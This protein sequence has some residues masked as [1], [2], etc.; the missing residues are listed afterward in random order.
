[1]AT[2]VIPT[3]VSNLHHA[4]CSMPSL[5]KV[6]SIHQT[7]TKNMQIL[8][9]IQKEY[10]TSRL[11][12]SF[13][14][15]KHDITEWND[16]TPNT[17]TMS[18]K[19]LNINLNDE[20]AALTENVIWNKKSSEIHKL[21]DIT[22]F[23]VQHPKLWKDVKNADNIKSMLYSTIHSQFDNAE[24]WKQPALGTRMRI[25]KCE[26]GTVTIMYKIAEIMH[27]RQTY[28]YDDTQLSRARKSIAYAMIS[29]GIHKQNIGFIIHTNP[30]EKDVV[31]TVTTSPCCTHGQN[32]HAL[33][34]TAPLTENSIPWSITQRKKNTALVMSVTGIVHDNMHKYPIGTSKKI[35]LT[36]INI[37]IHPTNGVDQLDMVDICTPLFHSR[38]VY[39]GR[40]HFLTQVGKSILKT[41]PVIDSET[42]MLTKEQKG[43]NLKD[44]VR[45]ATYYARVLDTLT[46]DEKSLMSIAKHRLINSNILKYRVVDGTMGN[47]IVAPYESS[48][49]C[50]TH[51][52]T[53]NV[54]I[55]G[56]LKV[57]CEKLCRPRKNVIVTI[58]NIWPLESH[59]VA[60][61]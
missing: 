18:A 61:N 2:S 44:E 54:H 26:H 10:I 16:I 55:K 47:T 42:A 6:E 27:D 56:S 12:K 5:E 13:D 57:P 22:A 29:H 58:D 25:F 60:F 51:Y 8:N 21:M 34:N 33:P 3:I 24:L 19:Q 53:A 41:R 36:D 14:I 30:T 37:P 31:I 15:E 4:L 9:N 45:L 17:R 46:H 7:H 48:V 28:D 38:A 40:I 39:L 1:M 23:C 20:N 49:I 59:V 35:S 32:F 50:D 52:I 11:Q 43:Y